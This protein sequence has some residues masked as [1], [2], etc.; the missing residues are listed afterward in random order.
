M[1]CVA[2]ILLAT[3]LAI[4]ANA[5]P[6]MSAC[7]RPGIGNLVQTPAELRS[8]G[9]KLSVEFSFRSATNVFGHTL[10]CYVE[11]SGAQAPTLRVKPGDEL[12]LALKNELPAVPDKHAGHDHGSACVG[13]AMTKSSTNL[14]FHGLNVPPKCHQD[15]VIHTLIGPSQEP[16][17]YR[18]HIPETQKPGLYWYHPH[19]H[20]FSEPQLLGGASGAL[21]VEGIEAANPE[22]AGLAERILILRDQRVPGLMQEAEDAGPGKDISLNFVPVMYPLYRPAEMPVK[23]NQREFWRVLNASAD[24]YFDLQLLFGPTIQDIHTPQ[25]LQLIA[26]D[27]APISPAAP[28]EIAQPSDILLPPGARAEFLVTTPPQ[29]TIA[30]LVTRKYDTGPFGTATPYRTIAN[31]HPSPDAPPAAS[32]I[33]K[34][35]G[36]GAHWQFEDLAASKPARQRRLYFSEMGT[37]P[38]EPN[39]KPAYFITVEGAEPKVFDMNF[40]HP[41]ITVRQGTVEDWV[42][43]N[44]AREA[45]SFHIHQLHFQLVERDGLKVAEGVL[46]DTIDLPYWDG[47]SPRYPTVTLRMDFRD[48]GI[49]GTFLYHCHILEHEDQGMMGSIR[50]EPH[51]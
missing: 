34:L 8:S 46:R 23:P 47:H 6:T 42:I 11:S 29:G 32:A 19:P 10:Y 14:H 45:H 12:E 36:G 28:E 41:D 50:V 49:A 26:V 43:E 40:Q 3:V 51:R 9:G 30:Q 25:R 2:L 20:G 27:G 7:P 44:R 21:I 13:G 33:P 39:A 18:I 4:G 48:P 16:F 24:T 35:S 17:I 38:A 15:E 5:Q 31:L 37:D 1:K 22:V